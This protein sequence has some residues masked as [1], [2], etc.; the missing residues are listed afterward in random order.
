MQPRVS[1]V[2]PCYNKVE[3]I[4]N[5]L[6]TI[7]EQEWDNIE[8]ILVNDGSTDGTMD[9]LE[10]WKPRLLARGFQVLI[11][12]QHNQ[13][14]QGAVLAGLKE[15]TGDFFC[16]IDCDDELHPQYV[17]T[18][19]GF[20]VE[21]T[22]YEMAACHYESIQDV[23]KDRTVIPHGLPPDTLD[24]P[25]LIE[26]FLL[27]RTV[28]TTWIYMV[29]TS[30]AKK[31][32]LLEGFVTS[33]KAT[34]EPLFVIPLGAGGGR[35][36]FFPQALYSHNLCSRKNIMQEQLEKWPDYGDNYIALCRHAIENLQ[37][38]TNK[39]EHLL[40]VLELTKF[41]LEHFFSAGFAGNKVGERAW[42]ERTAQ[43]INQVL[44]NGPPIQATYIVEHGADM[45]FKAIEDYV[46]HKKHPYKKFMYPKGRVIGYGALDGRVDMLLPLIQ[47]SPLR[48]AVY[49]DK[50]ATGEESVNGHAIEKPD[51]TS[52]TS[53]DIILV[54][55][56]SA[57]VKMD[58][59]NNLPKGVYPLMVDGTMIFSYRHLWIY[60]QFY[61]KN[62]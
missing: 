11:V 9:I 16:S 48:P 7:Y 57:K 20:L 8:L 60:P 29:R 5:T 47:N 13:G 1:I 2:V 52:V 14:I 33:P 28:L 44:Q 26:S 19:A 30:Y 41:R 43:A 45:L 35:L 27:K 17:S 62:D 4:G 32:R 12:D 53:E 38:A 15:V 58:L 18:L 56:S 25:H 10:E 34:Q 46:L 55:P 51:C 31:C 42:A 23:I 3:Y 50:K 6:R 40:A 36:K 37:V 24:T 59:W 39:R 49:W 54:F 21:N 22:G 61:E